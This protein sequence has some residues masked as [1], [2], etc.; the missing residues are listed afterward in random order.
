MLKQPNWTELERSEFI[1][2]SESELERIHRTL[3]QMLD[4]SRR[5]SETNMVTSMHA[6]IGEV[7]YSFFDK[8]P[9][10]SKISVQTRLSASSEL[11]L[12][13][14][15]QI[16][17]VLVNLFINAA[18]A[19]AEAERRDGLL[20]ITTRT[21]GS[22]D[23]ENQNKE[24]RLLVTVSDNGNGIDPDRLGHVFDPFYD[25]TRW[26]RYR[27]GLVGLHEYYRSDKRPHSNTRRNGKGRLCFHRTAGGEKNHKQQ[28]PNTNKQKAVNAKQYI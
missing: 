9:L 5:P 28:A 6:L 16:R 15:A 26:K 12:G 7:V 8:H 1:R 2:R 11:V 14:P 22:G 18:D 10:M 25:K 3:Q 19:I 27:V 24:D 17:Q 20:I 4:L 21:I 13:D 23:P